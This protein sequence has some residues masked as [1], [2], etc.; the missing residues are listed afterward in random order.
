[1]FPYFFLS[2]HN[3]LFPCL[4]IGWHS[5]AFSF[6]IH[7]LVGVV[8]G[9]TAPVKTSSNHS[10]L[11]TIETQIDLS[12]AARCD[13]TE[14]ESS[15]LSA[16]V[17]LLLLSSLS[18]RQKNLQPSFYHWTSTDRSDTKRRKP[19]LYSKYHQTI[20]NTRK[21]FLIQILIPNNSDGTEIDQFVDVLECFRGFCE[22]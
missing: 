9:G 21:H 3:L 13:C 20:P 2:V 18:I 1:M 17:R 6:G 15:P 11:V 19:L 7:A 4:C 8:N 16:A 14:S 5:R 22:R 12:L 10:E